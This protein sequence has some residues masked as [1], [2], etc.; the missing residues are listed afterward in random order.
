M[1][2]RALKKNH[3][4]NSHRAWLE[5]KSS[6][7]K[8]KK[9]TM[10]NNYR[11]Q[12]DD[13]KKKNPWKMSKWMDLLL[14]FVMQIVWIGQS[15][16]PSFFL[17]HC[18]FLSPLF[19]ISLFYSMTT[20]SFFECIWSWIFENAIRIG[21]QAKCHTDVMKMQLKNQKY[22][23][24]KLQRNVKCA[25]LSICLSPN[26]SDPVAQMDFSM[27]LRLDWLVVVSLMVVVVDGA[28]YDG[29]EWFV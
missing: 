1:S 14:K 29:C 7:H 27:F 26:W 28:D 5:N 13:G 22:K 2:C 19:S 15:M 16:F 3:N 21:F 23:R 17:L 18:P 20:K 25:I 10:K 8:W 4:C 24:T 11:R 9:Q 12:W 6:Q